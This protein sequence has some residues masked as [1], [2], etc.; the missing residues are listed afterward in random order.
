MAQ[1]DAYEFTS[2]ENETIGKAATWAL[3]LAGASWVMVA[4]HL[5]FAFMGTDLTDLSFSLL[6]FDLGAGFV[7]A[8]CYLAAGILF[9]IVGSALRRVVHTEGSDLQHMLKALNT[10]HRVFVVRIMLVFVTVMAVVA[11]IAIGEG[12]L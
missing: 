1:Q 5:V 8:S 12:L 7:S 10:L 11:V 9:A 4:V 2:R 6:I 3:A